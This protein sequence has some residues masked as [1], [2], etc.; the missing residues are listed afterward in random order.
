MI[1]ERIC[2]RLVLTGDPNDSVREAAR[3]MGSA[4]LHT[5]VVVDE[6]RKPIGIVTDHDIVNRC[7]AGGQDPDLMMVSSLMT[8]PVIS[9]DEKVPL[10]EALETMS[11]HGRRHLIVT[12]DQGRLAGII[13]LSD[14]LGELIDDA[15]LLAGLLR[16]RRFGSERP[17]TGA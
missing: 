8:S 17:A 7:V 3:R 5:L 10:G 13:A 16:Q 11:R 1:V 2:S 12:D 14:L 6:A 15:R 9:I 4:K